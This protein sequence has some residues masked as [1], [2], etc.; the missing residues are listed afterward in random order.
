MNV[1]R[2]ITYVLAS[3]AS[4][5]VIVFSIYTYAFITKVGEALSGVT[6]PAVSTPYPE[7]PTQLPIMPEGEGMSDEDYK[8]TLDPRC[9]EQNPQDWAMV[10]AP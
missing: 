9:V 2:V 4:I 8:A 7:M 1:L 6:A 10:C 5:C 3:L